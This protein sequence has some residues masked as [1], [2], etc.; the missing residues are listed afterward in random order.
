MPD[1]KSAPK[2]IPRNMAA[3]SAAFPFA[4]AGNPA[5]TLLES[6]V[7]NCFPGL[8]VDLRNLE[9]RFFPFLTVDFLTE[10]PG[11][12]VVWVDLDRMV[13]ARL[14]ES[15]TTIY[16]ALSDHARAQLYWEVEVIAADFGDY[17]NQIRIGDFRAGDLP[18]DP[19]LPAS[20]WTAIRLLREGQGIKLTLRSPLQ[21][22]VELTGKRVGYFDPDG[23]LA[24]IF[25]SGELTQSLCSPW[26]HDFRDCG[27]FYWASNHP[28]IAQP[29]SERA[30]WEV[31][32]NRRV[33]WLR[34]GNDLSQIPPPASPSRSPRAEE[35]GY[36]EINYRWQ[37]LNFVL[38]G[39]ETIS[40]HAVRQNAGVPLPSAEA[41]IAALREAAGIELAVMHEY[42]AAAFSLVDP[43][44]VVDDNELRKD[45]TAA[46]AEIMRIAIGEM[47]HLRAVNVVLRGLLPPDSFEPAL[48]IATHVPSSDPVKPIPSV[49]RAATVEALDHFIAIERAAATI[50]R[51]YQNIQTTLRISGTDDQRQA[52]ETILA[53][54]EDHFQAF[55]DI[56]EW[57]SRHQPDRVLRSTQLRPAPASEPLQQALDR[58]YRR[59]LDFLYRGYRAGT[60]SGAGLINEARSVMVGQGGL[61]GRA[62][63]LAAAGFLVTF[64]V[65]TDDQRFIPLDQ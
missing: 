18:P 62:K 57:L 25:T 2:L 16:R 37:A 21:M 23:A 12:R 30:E 64:S 35:M 39:R 47:R 17:G 33:V 38:G 34:S 14:S 19:Q 42:I 36:F 32:E 6:G 50:D 9:R 45:V 43:A 55:S 8:E 48:R 10:R 54:G 22:T 49:P 3:W 46:Y 4:T 11:I 24:E 26:T 53:E 27:C 60:L 15:E 52:I 40:P 13:Q 61:L 1:N 59:V 29:P 5:S 44:A 58:E 20:P 65:V 63:E 41:L 31:A 56:R 51:L 7:G 28:D